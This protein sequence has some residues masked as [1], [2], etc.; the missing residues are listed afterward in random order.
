MLKSTPRSSQPT[1]NCN[2]IEI[3][4]ENEGSSLTQQMRSSKRS[5]IW[6]HFT[7]SKDGTELVFHVTR[8]DGSECLKK[9]KKDKTGSTGNYSDH[10]LRVHKLENPQS[11]HSQKS[12]KTLTNYVNKKTPGAKMQPQVLLYV[13][14]FYI[15]GRELT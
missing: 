7:E 10:L 12:Q 13:Q 14:F 8:K 15:S 4:D 6:T 3:E 2:I 11:A 5:W 9:I 1:S